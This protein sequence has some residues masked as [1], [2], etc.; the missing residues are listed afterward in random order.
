MPEVHVVAPDGQILSMDPE[1]G[2]CYDL[3]GA[4]MAAGQQLFP[5]HMLPR[6]VH[7]RRRF[8]MAKTALRAGPP[9][10]MQL[11]D[12]EYLVWTGDI[13]DAR[14]MTDS[15]S[16]W[17]IRTRLLGTLTPGMWVRELETG[18]SLVVMR[19]RGHRVWTC[20]REKLVRGMPA[21][22]VKCSAR[23]AAFRFTLARHFWPVLGAVALMVASAL[24][25]FWLAK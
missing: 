18:C 2:D 24:L 16:G 8:H 22:W 9:V 3:E 7:T 19:V 12:G 1:S 20:N 4:V 17:H 13:E 6:G 21:P 14:D 25:G 15:P 23:V 5:E 10:D 11:L